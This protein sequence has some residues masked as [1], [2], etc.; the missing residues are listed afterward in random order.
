MGLKRLSTA[1][2]VFAAL[3]AGSA[4]G[5]EISGRSSTQLLLYNNDLTQ[6][7]AVEAAEY[8]RI[9]V[10]K[11]RNGVHMCSSCQMAA[12]YALPA[13]LENA[14]TKKGPAVALAGA[15]PWTAPRPAKH[16]KVS[17]IFLS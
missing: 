3:S 10:S 13:P 7:R 9:G 4:F 6:H 5:A 2:T 8:L 17:V 12:L 16:S 1:L 15:P 14:T 11:S